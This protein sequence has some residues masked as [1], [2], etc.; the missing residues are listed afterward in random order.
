MQ[1]PYV[2]EVP[3]H[4]PSGPFELL[5]DQTMNE[6]TEASNTID[7]EY[8]NGNGTGAMVSNQNLV[9]AGGYD[10]NLSLQRSLQEAFC[11]LYRPNRETQ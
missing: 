3:K 8:D 9:K 10:N 1:I 7:T 2:Y 11:C 4:D 5:W 6:V